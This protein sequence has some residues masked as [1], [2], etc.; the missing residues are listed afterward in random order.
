MKHFYAGTFMSRE[1]LGNIGVD[2][3]VKLEYYKTKPNTITENDINE[4][5]YGIEIIKTSYIK[6]I[7]EVEDSKIDEVTE[8]EC[9]INKI[10]DIL[11]RNEV[12]PIAAEYVVED[13]LKEIG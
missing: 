7:T 2:Y 8:D 5:K 11:K 3:P 1:D 12:T 13:L 9:L 6:N 10:L 4:E